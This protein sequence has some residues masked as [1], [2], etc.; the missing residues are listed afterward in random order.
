MTVGT[1]TS[2]S[3]T[4]GQL[5]QESL[6]E[7][8]VLSEE[9]ELQNAEYV[10]IQRRGNMM[11]KAWQADGLQPWSLTEGSFALVQG[12]DSYLFGAGGTVTTLPFS[13]E[14]VRVTR[15]ND[16]EMTE[17]SREDYFRLPNKTTQSYPIQYY[18]DRQRES[19]RLYVWPTADATLGT[20]KF[21]YRRVIYDI[22][23]QSETL[24]VPQEWYEAML[25]GLADRLLGLY[26]KVGS[27]EGNRVTQKA[28][29][30]YF[31]IEGFAIGEGEGSISI[32]P[33]G[34]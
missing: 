17:L 24:D 32:L 9:E 11:L 22:G 13:M 14:Q 34:Y 2:F 29:E 33:G 6:A 3:M 7:I 28:Q 5:A 19:G 25:Y 4:F 31:R 18:Y 26:G 27:P 16:I 20:I 12:T 21:T 1:T 15:T 30:A 10:R 23:D 8:G